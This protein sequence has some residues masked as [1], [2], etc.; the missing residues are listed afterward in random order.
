MSKTADTRKITRARP[1]APNF[2]VPLLVHSFSRAFHLLSVIPPWG[3]RGK[4]WGDAQTERCRRARWR[5]GGI[6][7][8][9]RSRSKRIPLDYK[10]F[11]SKILDASVVE[12]VEF[13]P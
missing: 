9:D 3:N 12:T 8:R 2:N 11:T 13:V 10:V 4:G 6:Q 1:Y 7:G 5:V